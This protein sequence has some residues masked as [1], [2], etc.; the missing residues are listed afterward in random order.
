MDCIF[1][2]T[3]LFLSAVVCEA[4]SHRNPLRFPRW[5]HPGSVSGHAFFCACRQ[6]SSSS[7]SENLGRFQPSSLNATLSVFRMVRFSCTNPRRTLRCF[8]IASSALGPVPLQASTRAPPSPRLSRPNSQVMC[9]NR[10]SR[11][12]TG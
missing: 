12:C 7:S 1:H 3:L 11:Q 8:G 6:G 5:P 10:R 9:Q 2:V 4:P